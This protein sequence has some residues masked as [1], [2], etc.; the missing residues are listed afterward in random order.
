MGQA[1]K[2]YYLFIDGECVLCEKVV[3]K[4]DSWLQ[5]KAPIQVYLS[6]LQN[7]ELAQKQ[8]GIS[9]P[10]NINS[11]ILWDGTK[12]FTKMDVVLCLSSY[13]KGRFK[14]FLLLKILPRF[15]RN[16]IYDIIATNRY[17]WFGKKSEC[18]LPSGLKKLILLN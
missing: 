18:L 2:T 16:W 14:G 15:L 9:L 8:L 3:F 1:V 10:Q 5:A 4:I 7:I 17:K 6:S 12:L 13:M 11:V